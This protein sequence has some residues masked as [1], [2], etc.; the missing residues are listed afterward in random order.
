[1]NK[2][3][4]TRILKRTRAIVADLHGSTRNQRRIANLAFASLIPLLA[5]A[6]AI[7]RYE[8]APPLLAILISSVAGSVVGVALMVRE[9][10]KQWSVVSKY[11][12]VDMIDRRLREDDA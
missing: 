10:I 8:L 11:V 7:I 9:A 6:V 5:V 1:M 2:D 4:E 12:D 3:Q